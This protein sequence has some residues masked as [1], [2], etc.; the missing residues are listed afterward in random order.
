[1]EN[2][3]LQLIEDMKVAERPIEAY[4][5]SNVVEIDDEQSIEDYIH[6]IEKYCKVD[7]LQSISEIIG[8]E[9]IQFPP[10]SRL[11]VAQIRAINKSYIRLLKTWSLEV[12]MPLGLPP[13]M[14]YRFLLSVLNRKAPIITMGTVHV[15]LC[16]YN[17]S[18]CPFGK[19][20]CSC[21]QW[22][23]S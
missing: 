22:D 2:Y 14:K 13:D 10:V 8:L 16:D 12:D 17:T 9:E 18:N 6:E 11:T 23:E 15:E 20:Y 4:H 1:M 5:S 7:G 3:V 19:E 21:R